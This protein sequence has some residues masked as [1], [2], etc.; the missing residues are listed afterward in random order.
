MLEVK[1]VLSKKDLKTFVTFP[2]KLYK[3]CPYWA[4]PLIQDELDTLDRQKNPAFKDADVWFYLAYRNGRVVGRIGVVVNYIETNDLN[5]PKIRFGWLDMIDDIEVTKAL[6]E[7]ALFTGK[8][9]GLK[10]AEGPMGF[11]NME[12]AGVLT[13]GY[14]E[15]N[16]LITWYH[17]PYYAE[18]LKKLGFQKAATWVEF[19][20]D[21]PSLVLDKIS[22]ISTVATK[23]YHLEVV[24]LKTKKDI[25]ALIDEMFVLLNKSYSPL[26]TYIPLREEQKEYYKSK[27]KNFLHPD[28]IVCI[29]DDRKK[30]IAFSVVMPSFS[31]AM[32]KA[33]GKLFPLGW[34]YILDAQKQN[35]SAAFYLIGI[36]PYYQGKGVTAV[37]FK[38]MLNMFINKGIKIVETNPELIENKAVQS[39]WRDYNPTLHK[40]RSTFRKDI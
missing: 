30:L 38:E 28:Y 26:Q 10:Y 5:K 20:M 2:F 11:N 1:E 15:M 34:K 27:Y 9:L 35:D 12:K 7:R 22:R 13:L 4:P 32:K 36:D 21:V 25:L 19:K 33:N 37:I 8:I 24:K 3:N 29:R 6:I 23:R 14:D 31:K 40:K 17:Y 18:H 39:L 16:T